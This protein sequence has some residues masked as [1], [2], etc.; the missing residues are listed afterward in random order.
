MTANADSFSATIPAGEDGDFVRYF[1]TATNSFCDG[2]SPGD[3]SQAGQIYSYTVRA[4]ALS[5]NDLQDTKGYAVD[6]SPYTGYI[7]T[8][9]GVVQ[10]DSTDRLG[11]YYIQDAADMWSGIWVNDGVFTHIKGDEIEVTGTVEE[12]FGITRIN[13]VTSSTVVTPGVGEFAPVIVTT[14][15]INTG[16]VN[17]EAY[18][19]V[20]V[21]VVD[22]TVTNPHPD[23]PNNFGEFTI[24]DGSGPL[25]V[26]DLFSA[27]R[28]NLD[29]TFV[30]DQAISEITGFGYFSF[31]NAKLTPRNNN[32]VGPTGGVDVVDGN[33]PTSFN[34]EQNYPNP[35]NPETRIR[36]AVNQTGAYQLSVFNVLGQPVRTLVNGIQTPNTYEV[37]WDGRNDAGATVGS[38][39][40]FYR[41]TGEGL[42]IS[43]KMIL[44][45]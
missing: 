12:N 22:A 45:K 37:T 5:I 38:G 31:G 34:L 35:F 21:R 33:L 1:I 42:S 18:E 8:V 32:D 2:Q 17:T 13:F 11:D 14:G 25:R 23:A 40:Y 41:L 26:D 27:F 39:I 44:L 16:G 43:R 19:S 29:T 36:F 30:Q 6:I 3:T 9:R 28:G 10:S 20:L 15:E 4:G 24:D 7:V